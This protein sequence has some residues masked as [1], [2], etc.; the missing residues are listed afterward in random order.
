MNLRSFQV[1][2][3]LPDGRATAPFARMAIIVLML[4]GFAHSTR[5][6][7]PRTETKPKPFIT[8]STSRK[9]TETKQPTTAKVPNLA[10]E[11]TLYV[12]GY[13]H[14][15]TE[16]RWEYPQVIQEYLTKTMRNNFA[17]FEKYPHYIFK[18][19]GA[20]RYRLMKEY[21]PADFERLKHYVA[22]GRWFPAGSSMEEGDVNS[23]NAESI[24]RQ[25]LYGNNWFR[26]EFGTASDEYMLPDC[27]GFPASLP[28]ILAHSGIKGF[29][30]QKLS[31]GWQPA[32]HVGG[33]DSPEK[34]PVGIPFNVG[35]WE[36]PDGKSIIAALNPL[37]YGSQV[38]YD[39][40]KTPP[41]LIP[42]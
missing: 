2:R 31:S 40:S 8:R 13:A 42:V 33:P 15:D 10:K 34:T 30:T 28:S 3:A 35:L 1:I 16:W 19:T 9:Q 25:I 32:P 20:N 39:I 24:I 11:P 18:F 21:Y 7:T 12:V 37:G 41:P 27:F 23:P 22:N 14:L 36:G 38:T 29:S 5:S 26:Q 4:I 6:Q 17:L